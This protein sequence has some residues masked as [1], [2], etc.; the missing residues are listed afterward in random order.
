MRHLTRTC[1]TERRHALVE[2]LSRPD[3]TDVKRGHRIILEGCPHR[4]VQLPRLAAAYVQAKLLELRDCD[5]LGDA[6]PAAVA[7]TATDSVVTTPN[8]IT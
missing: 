1:D 7:A 4:H 3:P 2:L 8:P 5:A 6:L